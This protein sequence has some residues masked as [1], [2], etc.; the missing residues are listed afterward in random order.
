[1]TKDNGSKAVDTTAPGDLA[2]AVAQYNKESAPLRG[3]AKEA[4]RV[5]PTE[6]PKGK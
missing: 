5:K 4:A 2:K 1:M 3:D 6:V